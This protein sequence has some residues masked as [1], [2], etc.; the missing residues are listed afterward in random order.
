[1]HFDINLGDQILPLDAGQYKETKRYA[2][3]TDFRK[4][5]IKRSVKKAALLC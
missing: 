4:N 5:K 2:H 3:H 1:M